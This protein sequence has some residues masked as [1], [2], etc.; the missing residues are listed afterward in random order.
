[1]LVNLGIIARVKCYWGIERVISWR[2]EG[3]G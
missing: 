2:V 3:K 1:M